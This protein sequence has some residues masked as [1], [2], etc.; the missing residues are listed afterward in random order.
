MPLDIRGFMSTVISILIKARWN[1]RSYN[2][3]KDPSGA[4]WV[5][6]SSDFSPDIIETAVTRSLPDIDLVRAAQHHNGGGLEGGLDYHNTLAVMRSLSSRQYQYKCTLEAIMTATIW[7]AQRV[8]DINTQ[9]SPICPRCGA[10]SET[11][12]HRYWQCKAN[13]NI[14]DEAVQDTQHLQQTACEKAA[15]EPCLWLRGILPQ[16]YTQISREYNP[17]DSLCITYINKN[18]M[19]WDSGT[20]YGDASGG[21]F[22]AYNQLRRCGCGLAF[23]NAEGLLVFGSRFNLPGEVQT[24]ARGELFALVVLI[25]E[26]APM[27]IID[28][29]T[30]N[31]GVCDTFNKG[32]AG[33]KN[34]SNCDLYIR[35]FKHTIQK[36]IKLSV[37]WMPSHLKDTDVRPPGVSRLDVLGNRHADTLAGDAATEV[38][39]PLA[40]STPYLFYVHLVKQIQR[41]LTSIVLNLPNVKKVDVAKIQKEPKLHIDFLFASCAHKLSFEAARVSCTIC[42]SSFKLTDGSLRHW[43]SCPCT[44]PSAASSSEGQ[45]TPVM[46]RPVPLRH[47]VIHLGNQ[48]SHHTHFLKVHRGLVYCKRCGSRGSNNQL[49]ML[50]KSCNPPTAAGKH[51][52]KCIAKDKLPPNLKEWPS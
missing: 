47:S 11:D 46:N 21:E 23:I 16:K 51:A 15:A 33:C 49:R 24:V 13:N 27:A 41:R 29:V 34:S 12:L 43:L 36:A 37:R 17:S 31:K 7:T 35:L 10:E 8:H 42:K 2:C 50:A 25:D 32:P 9:V 48:S 38:M 18:H 22:T 45:L 14:E 40:A 19:K 52:L 26:L 4:V 28:F 20:Y 1:P 30:D 3:W 6:T 5:S 39:V 44:L